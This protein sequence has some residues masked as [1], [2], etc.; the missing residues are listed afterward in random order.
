MV[1]VSLVYDKLC[2]ENGNNPK[3]RKKHKDVIDVVNAKQNEKLGINKV[4]KDTKDNGNTNKSLNVNVVRLS[5]ETPNSIHDDLKRRAKVEG[6]KGEASSI[7]IPTIYIIDTDVTKC[8]LSGVKNLTLNELEVL[9]ATPICIDPSVTT[10]NKLFSGMPKTVID[11]DNGNISVGLKFYMPFIFIPSVN[12]LTYDGLKDIYASSTITFYKDKQDLVFINNMGS[13]RAGVLNTRDYKNID[14][15]NWELHFS[16]PSGKVSEFLTGNATKGVLPKLSLSKGTTSSV[17]KPNGIDKNPF[18]VS[19]ISELERACT[20]NFTNGETCIQVNSLNS[21]ISLEGALKDVP[22]VNLPIY[23][24]KVCNVKSLNGLFKGNI[25]LT[26]LPEIYFEDPNGIESISE[27]FMG[28]RNIKGTTNRQEYNTWLLP[29]CL[30]ITSLFEGCTIM[31]T[32]PRIG[33]LGNKC[34]ANKICKGCE[35]LVEYPQ[36]NLDGPK[37]VSL[38]EAFSGCIN[39]RKCGR[40]YSKNCTN[41]DKMYEECINLENVPLLDGTNARSANKMFLHCK[42]LP[43]EDIRNYEIKDVNTNGTPNIKKFKVSNY[44]YALTNILFASGNKKANSFTQ[45]NGVVE[46]TINKRIS[47]NRRKNEGLDDVYEGP[48]SKVQY[49]YKDAEKWFSTAPEEEKEG[50]KTIDEYLDKQGFKKVDP[51]QEGS[52]TSIISDTL[53][54]NKVGSDRKRP[55]TIK[56]KTDSEDGIEEKSLER[57]E[58]ALWLHNHIVALM[59]GED[60]DFVDDE[61]KVDKKKGDGLELPKV[62]TDDSGVACSQDI[63]QNAYYKAIGSNQLLSNGVIPKKKKKESRVNEL[64][65]ETKMRLKRFESLIKSS[66]M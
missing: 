50:A 25:K 22:K 47:M 63:H 36:D 15:L 8:I 42:S 49:T 1:I 60:S 41:F 62:I 16:V 58:S 2:A 26:T 57:S 39:L 59:N 52:L 14:P 18:V 31:K 29:K 11:T 45:P 37:I 21:A 34:N 40:I 30:D 61:K 38:S 44:K 19:T 5:E 55:V 27:M 65:Q 4:S 6:F 56:Q 13:V 20:M 28:C 53:D 33:L 12:S 10:I 54:E 17:V 43:E 35:S 7:R 48:K 23:F 51:K 64:L 24:P 3:T 46:S 66:N 9:S 32:F